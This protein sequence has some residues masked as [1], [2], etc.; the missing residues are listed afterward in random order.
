VNVGGAGALVAPQRA[1]VIFNGM[2]FA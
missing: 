2:F 1:L